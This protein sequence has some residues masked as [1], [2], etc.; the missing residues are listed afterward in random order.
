M[1]ATNE[2][3]MYY[4][5]ENGRLYVHTAD[6][7][8]SGYGISKHIRR[9]DYV[10]TSATTCSHRSHSRDSVLTLFDLCLVYVSTNVQNIDSLEGFP[11]VIGEKIFAAIREQK[12]LQLSADHDCAAV[13]H[14]F[15]EAYGSLLLDELSINNLAI[16]EQHF[17]SFSAFH[18]VT[19]LDVTG[20][21]LGDSH[22]CL[23]H[24]GHLSL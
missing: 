13:L 6:S 22:D 15:D 24:I 19:K 14:L 7:I 17:E 18:H 20:C 3:G 4:V 10:S 9:H 1:E 5:R 16:L 2:F 23:L 21:L 12:I 8:S 11:D